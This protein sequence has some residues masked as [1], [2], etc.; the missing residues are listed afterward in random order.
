MSIL[1]SLAAV[2]ITAATVSSAAA[3]EFTFRFGSLTPAAG[4]I[5]STFLQPFA[6]AVERDSGGR[7]EIDLQ[8]VGTYG[9]PR[10]AFELVE[11]GVI[12]MAWTIQGYTSGRF[13]QSEVLELPFLFDKAETGSIALW[14]MYEE[15]LFER[16]YGSVQPLALYT[17][18]PYGVFTNGEA[19][20]TVEDFEGL[21][22]RA[23][24]AVS[25]AALQSIGAIPVGL[26]VTEMAEGLRLGTIDSTAF[27]WEA[28]KLFGLDG[29]VTSLTDTRLFAPR[30]I[31]V[32]N[33]ARFEALPE[34][35]QEIIRKH[36]GLA[37][38]QAIGAGLDVEEIR[39][40]QTYNDDPNNAVVVMSEEARATIKSR[41]Q[42][43]IET[44]VQESGGNGVDGAK[45]LERARQII[46][47]IEG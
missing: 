41:M 12:D 47:D 23:P 44:W 16:D 34:D 21:K 20:Q 31:V 6:D 5:H 18:R 35:L 42:P 8:P 7:I 30:F 32:M 3:Q 38:S 36:S 4:Y 25:A 22:I 37:L 11:S 29:L 19:V 15:G 14:K 33:K 46:A 39:V 45:L 17:H 43:V 24:S 10:Q 13:Q 27:P 28:I 26:Q 2:L 1:K 9:S 40:M